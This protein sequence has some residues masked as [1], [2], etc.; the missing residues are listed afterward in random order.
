LV[1]RNAAIAAGVVI[2]II[3]VAAAVVAFY[4]PTTGPSASKSSTI[5]VAAPKY[6]VTYFYQ[7]DLSHPDPAIASDLSG[8]NIYLNVYDQLITFD[9]STPPK[10]IPDLATKWSV[11]SDGLHYT[12]LL[13]SGVTFHD[14]TPL[15]PTDVQYS[16]DRMMTILQG[17]SFM[18]TGALK[19]GDT[20]VVNSTAVRFNL[21]KPFAPFLNTLPF[22]SILNS[23]VVLAHTQSTGIYGANG[24]YGTTWYA[25]GGDAGSGAYT[26]TEWKQNIDYKFVQYPGYWKGWKA[27]QIYGETVLSEAEEST[28]KA[29]FQQTPGA[30]GTEFLS[31]AFYQFASSTP[32]LTITFATNP[33]DPH[34]INLNTASAPLNNVHFRRALAYL[35]NYTDFEQN[36][37]ASG[38]FHDKPLS[39][40]ML[41]SLYPFFNAAAPRP[42]TANIAAA[43]AELAA[44]GLDPSQI[45][46][47]TCSAIQGIEFER[48]QC[49]QIANNAKQLGITVNVQNLLWSKYNQDFGAAGTPD[50]MVSVTQ[51][52]LY[53]DPDTILYN[54][55]HSVSTSH[56]WAIAPTYFQ[57]ATLDRLLEQGRTVTDPTQRQQIY[58]QIQ[59]ILAQQVPVIPIME[60]GLPVPHDTHIQ[61]MIY[62]FEYLWQ[63]VYYWTWNPNP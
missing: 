19:P 2:V 28:I 10:L 11:S 22:F 42:T 57:N 4:L 44:S 31:T 37:R 7:G 33:V 14:G 13:R 38:L 41:P 59:T 25:T 21:E 8:A 18:W 5:A 50:D 29:L 54:M 60:Q 45:R 53:L 12:F 40:G 30:F 55:F 32:G 43:K 46:P 34:Y 63:R 52:G 49:L 9:L 56:T 58:Y 51:A 24:D 39:W 1:S 23:K 16:M 48:L 35:F 17:F 27:G 3:V 15:T 20:Q 61:N 26:L 36:I 6:N 62:N 47:L